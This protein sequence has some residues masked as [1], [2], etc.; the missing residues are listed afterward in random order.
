MKAAT[1]LKLL[2]R[3]HPE[4]FWMLM[5][6]QRFLYYHMKRRIH[7]VGEW[8]Q[9]WLLY[10][11][12]SEWRRW[13]LLLLTVVE[14]EL[15]HFTLFHRTLWQ[16]VR[17][18]FGDPVWPPTAISRYER[19]TKL[20]LTFKHFWLEHPCCRK[21]LLQLQSNVGN[22]TILVSRLTVRMDNMSQPGPRDP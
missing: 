9:R 13:L 8:T 2:S 7:F 18:T 22:W 3:K 12:N 11:Q 20:L 5:E 10:W 6:V 17:P 4:D 16:T 15:W 14:H 21:L 19:V 1:T